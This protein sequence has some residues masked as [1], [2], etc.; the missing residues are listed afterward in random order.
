MIELIG[1]E[2]TISYALDMSTRETKSGFIGDIVFIDENRPF[3]EFTPY[4]G[5]KI[6]LNFDSI[7]SIEIIKEGSKQSKETEVSP[8][9][10]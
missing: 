6:L 1:A 5:H 10:R 7:I 8:E 4:S 9:V 2:A 3:L